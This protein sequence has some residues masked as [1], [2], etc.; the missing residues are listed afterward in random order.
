VFKLLLLPIKLVLFGFKLSGVKGAL[1]LG[2]GVVIG[3]FL[4]PQTGA[5]LRARIR[6]QL[7]A[8]AGADVYPDDVDLTL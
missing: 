8:K 7:M 1:W 4:A 3:L 2:L 6:A 5:E